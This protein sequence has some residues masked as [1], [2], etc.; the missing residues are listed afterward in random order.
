MD[1]VWL[2]PNI[3][4]SIRIV[5]GRRVKVILLRRSTWDLRLN[6]FYVVIKTIERAL[7]D[8]ETFNSTESIQNSLVNQVVASE[9][10]LCAMRAPFKKWKAFLAQPNLTQGNYRV[11]GAF[12]FAHKHHK[13]SLVPSSTFS[14]PTWPRVELLFGLSWVYLKK[15]PSLASAG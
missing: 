12:K 11:P 8:S 14:W 4:I 1:Y 3:V 2:K 13:L 9:Q 10:C 7:S 15:W 6:F 5:H